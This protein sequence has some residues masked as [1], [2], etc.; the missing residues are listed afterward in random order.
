[1]EVFM[2]RMF[3]FLSAL[4][5]IYSPLAQAKSA[6][7]LPSFLIDPAGITASG[8]SSGAYMAI[9]LD[10]AFSQTFHGAA[11]VAGGIFWCAE[12]QTNRAQVACMAVPSQ[13]QS[14]DQ[15]AYAKQLAANGQIDPLE[16]LGSHKL[17]VYA[18]P[19]DYIINPQNS[20]KLEEFY[21]AFQ[22]RA[23]RKTEHS[24]QSAHGWPTVDQGA[25]CNIGMSPWI[26]KCNFDAAGEILKQMYGELQPKGQAEPSHLIKFSQEE[27]G[28]AS[29]PLFSYGW[30]YVPA[31]CAKGATCRL[32]VALH[33]C[34]MTPD[35][36]QDQFART[37]G[38]NEWAETN[39]IVVLYPQS[40]KLGQA[41][42]YGCWDWFGF[43]GQNYVTKNGAQMA[44]IKAMVDRLAPP[45]PPAGAQQKH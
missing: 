40:A 1:M 24:I 31:S 4:F 28:N 37:I 5:C 33:G 30:V 21:D 45:P 19:K 7:T 20:D 42:P 41:N 2:P 38:F 10:V 35:D 25:P 22:G 34:Q 16:N 17:Y 18:S 26:L 39:N 32:H 11:S 43:T 6:E 23:Q 36:I 12:G 29:T 8:V 13:I 3:A 44:A 27:F 9:Q 14:A 15:I